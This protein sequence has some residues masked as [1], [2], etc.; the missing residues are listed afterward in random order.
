MEV[1]YL[2][3][4]MPSDFQIFCS[5]PIPPFH[6]NPIFWLLLSKSLM[7]NF[8]FC[9]VRGAVVDSLEWTSNRWKQ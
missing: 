6:L 5:I 9:A 8:I 1:L 4:K 3:L 2:N 7:E